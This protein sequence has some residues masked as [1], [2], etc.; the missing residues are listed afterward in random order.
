MAAPTRNCFTDSTFVEASG[1]AIVAVSSILAWPVDNFT[2]KSGLLSLLR[3]SVATRRNVLLRTL[4]LLSLLCL[5]GLTAAASPDVQKPLV[6]PSGPGL[7]FAIADFDGDLLP[8]L[9]SIEA[10]PNNSGNASYSIQ[11]QLTSAG[12]QFIQLV[13]PAGGLSITARDVNGDGTIDLILTTAWF[14]EPVAIFLNDGHGRFSRVELSAYPEAFSTPTTDW[15]FSAPALASGAVGVPPQSRDGLCPV[16]G[17]LLYLR[18]RPD[19]LRRST[20]EILAAPFLGSHAGR[21]PP[22]D[23]PQL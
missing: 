22:L 19:C 10:G 14:R 11:I 21:A 1:N 13:A 20:A 6:T 2:A 12:R 9:A 23:S 4:I 8:D 16:A 18:P 15:T 17:E 3:H 5:T 7:P